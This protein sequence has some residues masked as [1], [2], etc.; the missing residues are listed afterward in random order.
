MVP[1]TVGIGDVCSRVEDVVS[2]EKTV[3]VPPPPGGDNGTVSNNTGFAQTDRVYFNFGI[4]TKDL[5]MSSFGLDSII[6]TDMVKKIAKLSLFLQDGNTV[7]I[8][9]LGPESAQF[10][11]VVNFDTPYA[12]SINFSFV[13]APDWFGFVETGVQVKSSVTSIAFLVF[14]DLK[15]TDV[16]HK[17]SSTKENPIGDVIVVQVSLC[18][19]LFAN[20]D[21]RILQQLG[22]L[23]V[24]Q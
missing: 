22:N 20:S 4:K 21:S 1:F 5:P 24:C 13:F 17:V 15:R 2:I 23:T 3:D 8:F 6:A 19:C 14:A 7:T 10:L 18:F 12:G 9:P 11:S 16:I